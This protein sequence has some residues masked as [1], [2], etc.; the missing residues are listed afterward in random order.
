MSTLTSPH[1]P[2]KPIRRREPLT[3]SLTIT[4]RGDVYSLTSISPGEDGSR[5]WRLE[6]QGDGDA[7][8]DVI[9]RHDGLVQCSCPSWE[10]TYSNSV[11]T[12]KHGQALVMVGLLQAPKVET[13]KPL[14][15]RDIVTVYKTAPAVAP[16]D[17]DFYRGQ[18]AVSEG[19]ALWL[20]HRHL[21]TS[22]PLPPRMT[23]CGTEGHSAEPRDVVF[24][25]DDG[26]ILPTFAEIDQK[27]KADHLARVRALLDGNPFLP[28]PCCPVDEPMP[29]SACV[30]HEGPGDLS[31]DAW[32]DS[33]VWSTSDVAPEPDEPRALADRVD[34]EARHF[35]TLGTP[36]GDL[37]A[38][39]LAELADRVRFLGATTTD[40]YRDRHRALLDSVRSEAEACDAARR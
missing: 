29:C 17:A 13:H 11:S 39:H 38:R 40:A 28:A 7:V 34:V 22:D 18:N 4:I 9:R 12:C 23:L 36:F 15:N 14:V 8:Y 26:S 24:V 6:K 27:H 31:D 19:R 32:D 2:V 37:I 30:T 33:H 10:A 3:A 1:N 16:F 35:R 21:H 20:C 25:D 5:A